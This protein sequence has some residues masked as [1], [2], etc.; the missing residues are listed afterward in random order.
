MKS[1]SALLAVLVSVFAVSCSGSGDKVVMSREALL[2]KIQGAWAGQTIGCTYGGPTEFRYN[3]VMIPDSVEIK[4]PDGYIGWYY[5]NF[6]GLYDDVYMDL[7]FVDVFAKEGL[8]A[9]LGSFMNAFAYADYPLWHANQQARYNILNGLTSPSSGHWK[10]N[11]HADDIDFQIEADYAGIMS[12]GMPVAAA[13]FTDGIGH[14]MNYGDGWYGGVYVAAMYSLAFVSNDVEYVVTEALKTIPQQSRYWRCMNDVIQWHAQHPDDWKSCWEM[15]NREHSSDIGCPDG[16]HA[17]FNIDAVINSAY[18]IIGLL[19]GDGD[20]ERTMEISTRCGY[21]SD[22]NPASAAGILGTM[23]GYSG[24]PEKWMKNLRDVEDRAFAY[25]DISLNDVYQMSYSQALQVIQ[26]NGG[27]VGEDSVIISVQKPEPVRF[28]QSFEGHYPE[29]KV[30]VNKSL[31]EPM[32]LDFDA[33]GVVFRHYMKC[34]DKD[35][36]AEVEAVLD[37]APAQKILLPADSKVRR[38]QLFYAYDLDALPHTLELRWLNPR[39]DC[40][41]NIT[42]Y[43]RYTDTSYGKHKIV[44]LR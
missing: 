16:V 22:C 44:K 33:K 32:K 19:Y 4:W 10:I 29:S 6:P 42:D 1:F 9:P 39:S 34:P 43:V 14:I 20:F 36:V 3:G 38:L 26:D 31:H 41:L 40:V 7:T 17:P 30:I 21:D 13:G 12:P 5:D 15:C 8:D 25:T 2:D 37:G 11:P 35:Y 27:E 18:I 24:I 23:L 28:E